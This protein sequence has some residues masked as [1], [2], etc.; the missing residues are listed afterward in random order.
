[1]N[2]NKMPTITTRPAAVILADGE[3]PCHE[4]PLSILMNAGY[5]VCCDGAVNR[6]E[7]TGIEPD[8]I[9]GDCDSLSDEY[10][11]KYANIIHTITEQENNDQTKSVQFCIEKGFEDIVILGSCGKREDH[12]LGNISLLSEYANQIAN[13]S[14]ITNYGIFNA[15][16][17]DTQFNSFA[18]QQVS[19]F[20]IDRCEITVRNLKYTI[21]NRILTNWW[22]GTLNES[23]GNDFVVETSGRVIVFR[24]F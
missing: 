3:F 15:I 24:T 21:E 19:L 14:I 11:T 10:R 13:I 2:T 9:V 4:I 5:L 17:N 1:M 6:L 20:A 18:G 7:G 8:A 23:L 16:N 22:Q 12:T